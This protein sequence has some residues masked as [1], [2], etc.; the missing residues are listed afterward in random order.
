[1]QIGCAAAGHCNT[2]C[3][4][5]FA[6][7]GIQHLSSRLHCFSLPSLHGHQTRTFAM[8]R[9]WTAE[10]ELAMLE[11][12]WPGFTAARTQ[13]LTTTF[14]TS[15]YQDYFSALYPEVVVP[16]GA[17]EKSVFFTTLKPGPDGEEQQISVHGRKK[18]SLAVVRR[19]FD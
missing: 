6:A 15:V 7:S 16:E 1:M 4:R 18:V 9:P 5:F 17:D 14:L 13:D 8:G 3:P 2:M 11:E 19:A 12:R 10:L